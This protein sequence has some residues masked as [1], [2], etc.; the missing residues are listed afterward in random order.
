MFA[1][2]PPP[3]ELEEAPEVDPPPPEDPFLR[4]ADLLRFPW[5]LFGDFTGRV[6]RPILGK[7]MRSEIVLVCIL[8]AF[9]RKLS[10]SKKFQGAPD[11]T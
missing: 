4:I 11:G 9:K 2:T 6:G 5:S 10:Q 3:E 1:A 7:E 8:L